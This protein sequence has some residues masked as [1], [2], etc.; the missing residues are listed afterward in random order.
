MLR[1]QVNSPIRSNLEFELS[2]FLLIEKY[3]NG[4]CVADLLEGSADYVSEILNKRSEGVGL[5][6]LFFLIKR[7]KVLQIV[8]DVGKAV[9]NA[10]FNILLNQLKQLW[11]LSKTDFWL[12][13]PKLSQ[14]SGGVG[15]FCSK[16][17]AKGVNIC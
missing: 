3:V 14:V 11:Q 4:F 9:V 5:G 10:V 15:V 16:G 1:V 12:N 2:F 13:H 8:L 17:W 7:L 6:F